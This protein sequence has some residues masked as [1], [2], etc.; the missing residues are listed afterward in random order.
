VADHEIN[1][2]QLTWDEINQ[3][4]CSAIQ[5]VFKAQHGLDCHMKSSLGEIISEFT[6][7][8]SRWNPDEPTRKMVEIAGFE[9]ESIKRN[10]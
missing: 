1:L 2:P 5:Q 6:P 10:K 8:S 4:H 9:L 3:A 7:I